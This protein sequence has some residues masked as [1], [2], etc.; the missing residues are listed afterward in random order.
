MPTYLEFVES[1]YLPFTEAEYLPFAEGSY[2][3]QAGYFDTFSMMFGWWNATPASYRYFNMG[4]F[5]V[6]RSRTS[7][8]YVTRSRTSTYYIDRSQ[9]NTFYIGSHDL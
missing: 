3:V 6:A 1:E 7:T 9:T 4:T 5:Y 2:A 8:H